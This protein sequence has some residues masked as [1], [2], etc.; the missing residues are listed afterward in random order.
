MRRLRRS[1]DHIGALWTLCLRSVLLLWPESGNSHTP[2]TAHLRCMPHASHWNHS[3][4]KCGRAAKRDRLG[5]LIDI[6]RATN[7]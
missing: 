4:Q 7:A 1:V 5:P 2:S 3:L 6:C